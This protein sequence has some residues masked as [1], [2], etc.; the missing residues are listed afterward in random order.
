MPAPTQFLGPKLGQFYGDYV[1]LAAID[2]AHPI[3]SDTRSPD[4][5]VCPTAV[6]GTPPDVCTATE[7]NGQ[8]ANDQE[9]YTAT[10]SVP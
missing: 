1:G 5:F 3:W 8:Q 7:P 4:L 9:T 10:M 2:K 6:P